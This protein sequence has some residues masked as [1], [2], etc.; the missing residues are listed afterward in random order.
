MRRTAIPG[1]V[2]KCPWGPAAP[3]PASLPHPHPATTCAHGEVRSPEPARATHTG[4]PGQR[5]LDRHHSRDPPP[6]AAPLPPAPIQTPAAHCHPGEVAPAGVRKWQAA[7]PGPRRPHP[8]RG[9]RRRGAPAARPTPASAAA[10]GRQVPQTRRG[11]PGPSWAQV[12]GHPACAPAAPGQL[13]WPCRPGA[14]TRPGRGSGV[15]RAATASRHPHSG[16]ARP[17]PPGRYFCF[18]RGRAT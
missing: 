4:P 9:H 13:T 10:L 17:P 12:P 18:G 2:S 6:E 7:G 15:P 14:A 16:S 11:S 3:S 8:G 5:D 1:Q